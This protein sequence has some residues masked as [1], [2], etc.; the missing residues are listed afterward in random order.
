MRARG[1]SDSGRG[2]D[3]RAGAA[4]RTRPA[5]ARLPYGAWPS[6]ISAELLA[7]ARTPLGAVTIDGGR[8]L[9]EEHRAGEGGRITLV[10]D[11]GNAVGD[12]LPDWANVRTTVHEY[13]GGA[14][15][16][17]GGRT[18]F[19]H[20][21]DQRVY[22]RDPGGKP[23]PITPEP[24]RPRAHRYADLTLAPRIARTPTSQPPAVRLLA[25]RERHDERRV[26]HDI[27]ELSPDG[28]AEPTV[29]V[30]G[31]DFYAAPRVSPDGARL[32]WLSWRHPDMPWDAAQ[33]W[34]A[35]LGADGAIGAPLLVVGGPGEAVSQPS[36]APDGTLWFA[37]DPG[38]WWNL[39]RWWPGGAVEQMTDERA[40]Y[41]WPQWQFG[42]ASYCFLDDGRVAAIANARG[43]QRLVTFEPGGTPV[44]AKLPFTAIAPRLAT[45][46]RDV[47]FVA[48]A[49]TRTTAVIRWNSRTGEHRRL[50][51]ETDVP[52]AAEDLSIG[53]SLE[54]PTQGG[55]TAHA[56]FYP[57]R[58]RRVSGPADPQERPPLIV[59]SHGGP[60][61]QARADLDLAK[62]YWTTRGF[63]VVDVN[64]GGSTG[65]G[66]AYRERLRG[67]WGVVDVADCVNA[68]RFLAATGRVDGNRMAIRGGSAGGFTTL[69]ALTF[70]DVFAAGTSYFGVAD[71]KLLMEQTHDFESRYLDGLVG[72][73]PEADEVCAARSPIHHV[74]R[75]STP[76][77][78]LQGLEDAVVPPDQARVMADALARRGVPHA[79]IEFE[80]EQ[81]GFRRAESIVR[82]QEAELS[83]YGQIMGFDPPGVE[84]IA[85]RGG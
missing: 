36:W 32:A 65:F 55:R 64:Y 11:N 79:L 53:Q 69:C 81:H 14:Y 40:E 52:L 19:C 4:G 33:L 85:L 78:L 12:V 30:S 44:P 31:E 8:V 47:V 63:A 67:L 6:D 41:A 57:P 46:G 72:P 83:F 17:R 62:Q 82:A 7:R 34:V 70:A 58:N 66:R 1:G 84:R 3:P 77:L 80:G 22:L 27:V 43:V 35:D 39:F 54:F 38:G 74:D 37:N 20:F 28:G 76:V 73:L 13:G 75:L 49:L 26:A 23:R 45:D 2:D 29:L 56:L 16:V 68:A 59:V 50:K 18:W 10:A 9:W 51:E 60:T 71:I 42:L 15:A 21:D 5:V 25:V 61:G 24:P 48:G